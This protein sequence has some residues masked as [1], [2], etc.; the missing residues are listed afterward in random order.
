MPELTLKFNLPEESEDAE[1]TLAANGMH[2]VIWDFK[3]E[4]R[5]K[6]KYGEYKE[7]T[8]KLLEELSEFFHDKISENCISKLF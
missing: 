3:Q 4:L 2:S 7:E 6:L 1:I 5:S 8:Y